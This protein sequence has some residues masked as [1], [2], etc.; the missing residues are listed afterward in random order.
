MISDKALS[1]ALG[2][3][4][5]ADETPAA[6]VDALIARGRRARRT[7]ALGRS[8]A[9]L[10][11]VGVVGALTAAGVVSGGSPSGIGAQ[12][13]RIRLASAAEAT[14]DTT[15][16]FRTSDTH[17]EKGLGNGPEKGAGFTG[18]ADPRH[19][20]G[21]KYNGDI[22]EERVVDGDVYFLKAPGRNDRWITLDQPFDQAM[23]AGMPNSSAD[24]ATILGRLRDRGTVRYVGRRG[25]GGKQVDVYSFRYTDHID[26]A[27]D[28]GDVPVTGTATVGVDSGYVQ[29]ISA[30]FSWSEGWDKYSTRYS[31]YGDPVNVRRPSAASIAK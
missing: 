23:T 6:P 16:R 10:G 26:G 27:V 20:T 24:P 7:S 13:P 17:F 28:G 12:S 19:E 29:R 21:I 15:F 18:A 14:G 4:S 2:E 25:S 22:Y 8:V 5:D 30:T 3:L 9:A 1:S 31:R 11:V